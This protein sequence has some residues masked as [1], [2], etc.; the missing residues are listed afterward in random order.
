[1]GE[2]EGFRRWTVHQVVAQEV[3][4]EAEVGDHCSPTVLTVVEFEPV[5]GYDAV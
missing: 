5:G 3:K 4:R 1:M 2:C